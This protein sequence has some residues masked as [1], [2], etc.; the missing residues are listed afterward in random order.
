PHWQTVMK[1]MRERKFC[2]ALDKLERLVSQRLLEF[3]KANM[4]D[5]CYKMRTHI[6]KSM[7]NR[8]AAIRT[9]LAEY[10]NAARELDSTAP[11][12]TWDE[13]AEWTELQDFSLL[14]FERRDVRNRPWAKPANRLLMNNYFKTLRAQEEI[15]RCA[16]EARRLLA[17]VDKDDAELRDAIARAEAHGNSVSVALTRLYSYRSQINSQHRRRL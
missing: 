6:A 17:F 15:D 7:N 9:A 8:S 5:I 14:S 1:Y 11:E 10:N 13:I 12:V 2:L 16:V 3:T 4:S